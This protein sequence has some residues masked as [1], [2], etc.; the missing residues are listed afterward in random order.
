MSLGAV[1]DVVRAARAKL[2]LGVGGIAH[3]EH[4]NLVVGDKD[5]TEAFYF[6]GLGLTRDPQR[7]AGRTIWAN[8]GYVDRVVRGP[9]GSGRAGVAAQRSAP[10]TLTPC[11]LLTAK[12]TSHRATAH[13]PT[14][15]DLALA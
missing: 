15:Q 10:L 14:R 6:T 5:I 7:P 11:P 13:R 3:L 1:A 8:A 9:R 4:I 2:G 12:S